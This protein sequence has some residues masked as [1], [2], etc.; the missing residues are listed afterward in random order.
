MAPSTPPRPAPCHPFDEE[1]EDELHLNC[2]CQSFDD[3]LGA[4]P[5]QSTRTPQFHCK[6]TFGSDK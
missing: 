4:I 5:F 6:T 3:P 2:K 1:N